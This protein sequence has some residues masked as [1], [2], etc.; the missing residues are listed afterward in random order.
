MSE[1]DLTPIKSK[2][3]LSPIEGMAGTKL[4]GSAAAVALALLGQRVSVRAVAEAT[5]VSRQALY[6]DHPEVITLIHQLAAE[7]LSRQVAP[8]AA[9]ADEASDSL[10]KEK[11]KRQAAE[12]ERDKALHHLEIALSTVDALMQGRRQVRAVHP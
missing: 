7:P 6:K 9:P 4:R 8:S 3:D 5:G 1:I 2:I 12:T 10:T 11:Q